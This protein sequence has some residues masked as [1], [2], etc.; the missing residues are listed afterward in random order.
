MSVSA[1]RVATGMARTFTDVLCILQQL[2]ECLAELGWKVCCTASSKHQ[3]AQVRLPNTWMIHEL[4]DSRW[5]EAQ[6]RY[7][8]PA[9][10]DQ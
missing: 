7:T 9:T 8:V 5:R 3:G 4:Q 2:L 1:N 6:D 10:N